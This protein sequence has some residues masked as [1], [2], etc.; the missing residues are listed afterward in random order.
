MADPEGVHFE[1]KLFHFHGDLFE[2]LGKTNKTN[3]PCKFEPLFKKSSIR[4][5]PGYLHRSPSGGKYRKQIFIIV[6][7]HFLKDDKVDKVGED[8]MVVEEMGSRRSENETF[9][10]AT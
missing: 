6:F 3:P 4:S 10:L 7:T 9:S 2:K 5:C 8:G 1:A